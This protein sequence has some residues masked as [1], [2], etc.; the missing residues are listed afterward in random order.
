MRNSVCMSSGLS[1]N[2]G[3][4]DVSGGTYLQEKA[5]I[6]NQISFLVR[7]LGCLNKKLTIRWKRLRLRGARLMVS[8]NCLLSF[9]MKL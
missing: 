6:K 5:N 1:G 8:S 3:L 7:I 4:L 9:E 2:P